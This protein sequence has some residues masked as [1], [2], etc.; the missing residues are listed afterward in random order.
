MTYYVDVLLLISTFYVIYDRTTAH[1]FGN[2]QA[3]PSHRTMKKILDWIGFANLFLWALVRVVII[4]VAEVLLFTLDTFDP[5]QYRTMLRAGN[6]VLYLYTFFYM[7]FM[8]DLVVSAFLL[9]GKMSRVSAVDKPSNVVLAALVPLWIVHAAYFLFTTI[10][11][12]LHFLKRI[13]DKSA[14]ALEVTSAL[15]TCLLTCAI[16]SVLLWLGWS[17]PIWNTFGEPKAAAA[18]Y[19]PQQQ[20]YPAQQQQ[21]QQQ[22]QPQ[23]QY[24]AAQFQPYQQGNYAPSP[25]SQY[26]S[27]QGQYTPSQ[28]Y[29]SPAFQQQQPLSQEKTP[30]ATPA[31]ELAGHP[32]Q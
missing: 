11:Y 16:V 6:G 10:Y 25:Q 9:K 12:G 26:M 32:G 3:G 23:Y 21:Q 13:P 31:P 22:F 20:F 19:Q 4:V 1:F 30:T 15:E 7:T 8:I 29:A 2:F 5:D 17:K 24:P 28:A 27:P 18:F 14:N